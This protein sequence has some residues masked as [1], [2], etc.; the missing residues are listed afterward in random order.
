MDAQLYIAR[1]I[2][3]T[4]SHMGDSQYR[5]NLVTL[6]IDP[7]NERYSWLRAKYLKISVQI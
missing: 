7:P 5:E 6:C 4:N 1:V 3:I 2:Y